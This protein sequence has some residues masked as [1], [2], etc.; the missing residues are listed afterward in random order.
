MNVVTYTKY[1]SIVKDESSLLYRICFNK[2]ARDI[3]NPI[4]GIL[5]YMLASLEGLWYANGISI[6]FFDREF[7]I[8]R[9][10][11]V[12]AKNQMYIPLIKCICEW[13][14]IADEYLKFWPCKA[15]EEPAFYTDEEL[16]KINEGSDEVKQTEKH[17]VRF[18][19]DDLDFPDNVMKEVV[20][21]MFPFNDDQ[22][23]KFMEC[24]SE[25]SDR[26]REVIC[27]RAKDKLSLNEVG[28]KLGVTSERIRQ[29]QNKALRII[30]RKM[31]SLEA[32]KK[33]TNKS[34]IDCLDLSVRTWNCLKRAEIYTIE[35]VERYF[36]E[37]S[38]GTVRNMGVKSYIELCGK[39]FE[40]TGKR[41]PDTRTSNKLDL[42][43][44]TADETN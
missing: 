44:E 6:E 4:I 38:Y 11:D 30:Y 14:D 20:P 9:F 22:R 28:K 1:L 18:D 43:K 2:A 10:R 15:S 27:L 42:E 19:K 36:N 25:L 41:L 23:K 21:E 16:S 24:L 37:R 29:A 32:S 12:N 17:F 3:P 31:T 5:T 13:G 34:S 26:Q 39:F 35:D 40:K 33:I 7:Y 8:V